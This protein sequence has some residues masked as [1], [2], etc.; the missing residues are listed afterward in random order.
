MNIIFHNRTT[1]G[2]MARGH[3]PQSS[4]RSAMN[5]VSHNKYIIPAVGGS[6][7]HGLSSITF[8]LIR[9]GIWLDGHKTLHNQREDYFTHHVQNDWVWGEKYF[10]GKFMGPQKHFPL[11]MSLEF[12]FNPQRTACC[13][14]GLRVFIYSCLNGIASPGQEARKVTQ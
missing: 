10:C 1:P 4:E 8:P 5:I 6:G 2:I 7:L 11:K 3:L 12:T 13:L 14:S 9:E